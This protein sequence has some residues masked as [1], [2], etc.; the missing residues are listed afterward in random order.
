LDGPPVAANADWAPT[1]EPSKWK[2]RWEKR[3]EAKG[4]GEEAA[5]P[6]DEA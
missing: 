3:H 5:E 2:E 4:A 6:G 1:D